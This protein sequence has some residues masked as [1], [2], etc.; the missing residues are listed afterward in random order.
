[1]QGQDKKNDKIRR[2][3]A[4]WRQ[5]LT[6]EQYLVLREKGTERPFTGKYTMTFEKGVYKCAACGNEL[7]TSDSKFESSCGWPSFSELK[8][9]KAVRLQKD[10]SHGMARTEFFVPGAVHIWDT[11]SMMDLRHGTAL[12]H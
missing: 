7:F 1:M 4:E 8:N 11:S 5:I 12:L 10:T 3:E 2:T 9:N 6:P